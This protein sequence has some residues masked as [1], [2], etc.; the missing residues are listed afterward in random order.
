MSA[1]SGSLTGSND[2]TGSD[3]DPLRIVFMGTPQF[4]LPTLDALAAS[5]HD[6]VAVYT[7]PPNEGVRRGRRSIRT[8][9]HDRADQLGIPVLT[10]TR[11]DETEIAIFR[12][13]R[14][15]VAIVA[16]YGIILPV[17]VLEAP[18]HGCINVHGSILPRWRGAAP[19]QRAIMAGDERTGVTIMRMAKGLDTGPVHSVGTTAIAGRDC[20]AVMTDLAELG[21]RMTMRFI[22]EIG[23]ATFTE[24]SRFG[25]SYARMIDKPECRLDLTRSAEHL[26]RVI[27]ALSPAPGAWVSFGG[28]RL[29]IYGAEVVDTAPAPPGTVID[30]KHTLACGS[31]ALR[32]TDLQWAG[33]SRMPA[34]AITGSGK[35]IAGMVSDRPADEDALTVAAACRTFGG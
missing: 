17:P 6:V 3:R 32:I 5:R 2:R 18:A 25:A 30:D 14:A 33:R 8:P 13:H 19:V 35:L 20:A 27:R 16:A 12:T 15:D 4:A 21:A 10:P 23:S 1:S 28:V 9:V 11:M 31:G 29:K 26:E 7:K 22:A 24:Q 34:S